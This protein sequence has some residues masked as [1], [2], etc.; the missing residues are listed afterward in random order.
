[1]SFGYS[2]KEHEKFQNRILNTQSVRLNKVQKTIHKRY[3][4]SDPQPLLKT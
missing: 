3:S 1:M 2:S 4:K